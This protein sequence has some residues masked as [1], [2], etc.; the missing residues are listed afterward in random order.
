[1]GLVVP[2]LLA[3]LIGIMEFGW[4]VK[5]NMTLSS[6][7]REGARSASVGKTSTEV[8]TRITRYANPIN[9]NSS[10]GSMTLLQC[11]S[12]GQNCT[13]WP[14]DDT[15]VTPAR[16]GIRPPNTV[17]VVL[18]T[19][20]QSLTRFIPFLNNRTITATVTMRREA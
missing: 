7:A 3:L 4:L 15:S 5:N 17:R 19:Q 6:A 8:R 18:T 1:M 16:N 12:T 13:A 10:T 2:I 20:H 11:D 9:L 14:A